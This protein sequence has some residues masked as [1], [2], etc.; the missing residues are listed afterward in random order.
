MSNLFRKMFCPQSVYERRIAISK[1]WS[2]RFESKVQYGLFKGLR[3]PR[4]PNWSSGDLAPKLFGLYEM[5]V[6]KELQRFAFR[7]STL[8]DCGGADGF[9]A[10]GSVFSGLFDRCITFEISESGRNVIEQAADE[11]DVKDCVKVLGE[12]TAETM[13]A[14]ETTVLDQAVLLMDIEGGEFDVL[15]DAVVSKLRN[16]PC[17][18]EL[19]PWMVAD[20]EDKCEALKSR[21]NKTHDISIINTGCRDLS[22]FPELRSSNDDD[23]YLVASEGRGRCMDWLVCTPKITQDALINN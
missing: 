5:Q 4:Q 11:H 21:Y 20:G 23:R 22:I 1:Y 2:E 12:I 15:T 14:F 13:L 6:L 17:I 18:V 7:R 9:Y 8:I 19:H 10:V 3:L 16:V